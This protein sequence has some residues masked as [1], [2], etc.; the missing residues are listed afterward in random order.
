MPGSLIVHYLGSSLG[1]DTCDNLAL[2][3]VHLVDLV[4]VMVSRAMKY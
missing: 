1:R 4:M 2:F 3:C